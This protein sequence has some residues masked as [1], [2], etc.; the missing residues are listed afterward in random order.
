MISKQLQNIRKI[1]GA[2]IYIRVMLGHGLSGDYFCVYVPAFLSPCC[3]P[4]L[5]H[6]AYE[7]GVACIEV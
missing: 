5:H 7:L 1:C 6:L 2:F 4:F 3:F